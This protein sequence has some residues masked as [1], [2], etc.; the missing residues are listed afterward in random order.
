MQKTLGTMYPV[1]KISTQ[2]RVADANST[3]DRYRQVTT[4]IPLDERSLSIQREHTGYRSWTYR[5]QLMQCLN[6]EL[7]RD[8][9]VAKSEWEIERT[10]RLVER[11]LEDT[12]AERHQ[13][14]QQEPDIPGDQQCFCLA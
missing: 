2:E 6:M 4:E 13:W 12:F 9:E 3:R 5:L 1:N 10:I 14:C 11:N 8:L 7:G